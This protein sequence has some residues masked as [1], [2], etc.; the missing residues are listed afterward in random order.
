MKTA[1]FAGSFNPYTRGHHAIVQRALAIFDRV[2]VAIGCNMGK[3]GAVDTAERRKA[4][5]KVYADE[6]RVQVAVYSGLTMD[7]ARSIG[8]TALL[9]GVRSVK[10]FE[11]ERDLADVNMRMG[12]IETV[13]LMSSPENAAISSSL[14]R[15]LM[16]YGKDVKDLLP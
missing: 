16:A 8:A 15:E 13:I 5:E 7:Y 4:I 1:L 14:V 12:G 10:D 11:Y 3:E 6:P 9:R 2:V